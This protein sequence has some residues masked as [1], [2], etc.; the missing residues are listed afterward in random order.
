MAKGLLL[1]VF[2]SVTTYCWS[3]LPISSIYLATIANVRD[4]AW[5]IDHLGYL[6]SFNPNGYN[7]QVFLYDET[8]L[9]ASI[10]IPEEEQTDIYKFD[11]KKKTIENLSQSKSSEYSPRIDTY[12]KNYISCIQVPHGDTNQQNLLQIPLGIQ[13]AVSYR[14]YKFDKI[15]YYRPLPDGRD[16]CFLVG[17]PHLL[18]ICHQKS[19][20]KKVFASD[21]GRCFEVVGR[22]HIYFVHKINSSQWKLK[23]YNITSEISTLIAEMPPGTED[24]ALNENNEIFCAHGSKILK[25]GNNG[26]WNTMAD[27]AKFNINNLSRLSIKNNLLALVN[28]PN[29]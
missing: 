21:I 20:T 7:N 15:G 14:F 27:L 17:S 6:S 29:K 19:K 22:D 11:L 4:S 16:I 1:I 28:K 8:T 26:V 3:Q 25:L 2:F 24:F 9:L 23:A 10:G 12:Y 13:A 18:A 5:S